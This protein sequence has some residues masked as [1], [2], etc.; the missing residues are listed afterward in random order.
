MIKTISI[1]Y[2]LTENISFLAIIIFVF[3]KNI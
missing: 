1:F 3:S 2:L